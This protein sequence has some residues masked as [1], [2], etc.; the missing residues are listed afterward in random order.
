MRL[1]I[2]FVLVLAALALAACGG[3][4]KSDEDQITDAIT[5]S[6]TTHS[7]SN[8]TDLLTQRFIE[9]T[10]FDTGSAA[11]KACKDETAADNADSVKVTNVEGDGDNATA[12]V[13]LQGST[14]DGQT[15]KISLVKEG[16]QWKLDH[17]DDFVHFDQQ[18]LAD[19]FEKGFS[20]GK[21][22]LPKDQ[23]ACVA[24][25]FANASPS[26]VKEVILSGE[27]RA[28]VPVLQRCGVIG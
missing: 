2:A 19:A 27:P 20:S 9:Q 7:D 18:A 14:F 22:P 25:G 21:N 8:C 6:S 4:G 10:E 11:L 26:D 12:N 1:P 13:A 15:L 3:G 24:S 23:A 5:T 28:L 16:D 17:V